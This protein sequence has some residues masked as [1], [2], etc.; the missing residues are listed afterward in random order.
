MSNQLPKGIISV[1]EAKMLSEN[2]AKQKE[3]P[4][5]RLMSAEDNCSCWWSLDEIESY[6]AYAKQE[7]EKNNLKMNGIRIYM[8][9]YG[10]EKNNQS[11]LFMVPTS[12]F[13]SAVPSFAVTTQDPPNAPGVAP[14]NAGNDGRP[15]G[16]TY[17]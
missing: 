9:A 6:I 13:N 8:G 14:M 3:N 5:N 15:P 17:P 11:T 7:C 2:L 16:N 1:E 10:P 12:E 4:E